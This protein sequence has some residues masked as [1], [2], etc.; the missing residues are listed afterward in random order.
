MARRSVGCCV[1]GRHGGPAQVIAA[2]RKTRSIGKPSP[3]PPACAFS[4]VTLT[5]DVQK[6]AIAL[7]EERAL[8]WVAHMAFDY[9]SWSGRR[10]RYEG[11]AGSAAQT[12]R[13]GGQAGC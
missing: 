2:G 12:F 11:D 6:T 10:S 8:A 1:C 4:T 9:S 3:A 13:R 7:R 5:G